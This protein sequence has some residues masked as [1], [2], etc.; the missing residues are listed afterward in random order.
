MSDIL[1]DTIQPNTYIPLEFFSD[2]TELAITLY[3]TIQDLKMVKHQVKEAVKKLSDSSFNINL[4]ISNKET[5]KQ[6]I[7]TKHTYVIYNNSVPSETRCDYF[8]SL[9]VTCGQKFLREEN[10]NDFKG[11]FFNPYTSISTFT[12]LIMD[13][14]ATVEGNVP[15]LHTEQLQHT[16]NLLFKMQHAYNTIESIKTYFTH[17]Q[18]KQVLDNTMR[19]GLA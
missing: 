17:T 5:K 1:L 12:S 11:L 4:S 19:Q 8:P 6:E 7:H 14:E 10:I 16:E 2:L 9:T 18:K 3:K 15:H 13:S